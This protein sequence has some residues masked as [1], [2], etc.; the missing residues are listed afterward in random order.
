[1]SDSKIERKI[2]SLRQTSTQLQPTNA[3]NIDFL[4]QGVEN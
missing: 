4:Q 2:S 1:M 3:A